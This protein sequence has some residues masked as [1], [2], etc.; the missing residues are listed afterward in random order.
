MRPFV[1]LAP[2]LL[3]L[4]LACGGATEVVVDAPGTLEAVR[5]ESA[6]PGTVVT[7]ERKTRQMSGGSCGHSL[8]C[9]ILVPVLIYDALFPETWDE[10]TITEDGVVTYSGTFD[11]D[12]ELLQARAR[13]GL[14]W[15][16]LR[17]FDLEE[18]GRS[19]VLAVGRAPA[20]ADGSPGE[21]VPVTVQ[22]QVDVVG[23]YQG[24]LDGAGEG[25]RAELLVEAL[26]WLGDEAVPMLVARLPNEA[27][28]VQAE[29]FA[30]ACTGSSPAPQA[31]A[32]VDAVPV[33]DTVALGLSATCLLALDPPETAR[34]I[35]RLATLVDRSCAGEDG[36]M[37]ALAGWEAPSPALRASLESTVTARIAACVD[38]ARRG[39]LRIELG[40]VLTPAEIEATLVREG[41]RTSAVL[42]R[43]HLA[44]PAH[45]AAVFAALAA[46]EETEK[47]LTHLYEAGIVPSGAEVDLL[48]ARLTLP[49]E[50][51]AA[52]AVRARALA[53][54][55]VLRSPEK[56]RL[57][58]LVEGALAKGGKERD[59][60]DWH[61]FLAAL[62]HPGHVCAAAPGLY[63]D[64]EPMADIQDIYSGGGLVRYALAT[65]GLTQEELL[66]LYT[67]T[68]REGAVAID[69]LC[70]AG[71]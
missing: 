30:A 11:T 18:L 1:V 61:A 4:G 53:F 33:P 57:G 64:E 22:S 60:Y 20:L 23:A 41:R 16:D 40:G 2:S 29:V 69:P 17:R 7:V 21:S 71:R 65:A 46:A 31:R 25:H 51:W 36:A 44:D 6:P 24:A 15:V 35:E 56:A 59:L 12:G 68:H 10:A 32:I 26:A 38:P 5:A 48:G 28:P 13:E 9:V 43:T 14:G 3:A 42:E 63:V 55:L 45:R 19:Y 58:P 67:A 70:A 49:S 50:G 62:G 52:H 66:R 34:A 8:F 27:G 54:G 39:E 47:I 37:E